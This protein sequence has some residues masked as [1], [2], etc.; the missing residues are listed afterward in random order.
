VPVADVAVTLADFKGFK[1]EAMAMGER[2]PLAAIDAPAS[3]RMA[4]AEAI[5][6]LLAAPIELSAVKLSANWMAACGEAGEDAALY[7]TVKAVGMELC[8]ALGISIP[9]GKDSLSMRTQWS[10]NGQTKKVTSPVSLIVTGFAAIDDV[11]STL[12]PQLDAGRRRHHPGAD[13]LG[14]GKMRMGGSILGQVLNQSGNEVP[15]LDEPKDLIGLVDAV[16]ALRAK[17]QILA[18]HDRATAACWPPWPKWPLPAMWAWPE[19]GHADHRRRRHQRQPHGQRRRQELG[20]AG[21]RPPRRPDPARAVQRRTGRR[22]ADQDRRPCRSAAGA[23]RAWPVQCSHV[24]GKT[25]PVSSP[26]TPAR[27][28]CRSGAMPRRCSAPRCPICTRS[29]MPSWKITQQR[30]NPPAPTASTLRRASL[31]TPACMCI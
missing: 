17:G 3:G 2:T 30:D 10:E 23:A 1:G 28:S 18:Y 20:Q 24:I 8:P 22:A 5:T 12:T 16:N 29:G 9:V 15:D 31:P 14:R 27:A 13:R 26:S 4:V 19:C 7:A 21:L 25:R 6:N 11:R